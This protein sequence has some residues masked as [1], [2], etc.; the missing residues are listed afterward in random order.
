MHPPLPTVS[1]KPLLHPYASFLLEGR[2][3][4][5]HPFRNIRKPWNVVKKSLKQVFTVSVNGSDGN[6]RSPK[7]SSLSTLGKHKLSTFLLV[8]VQNAVR[9]RLEIKHHHSQE[10]TNKQ[11]NK[12]QAEVSRGHWERVAFNWARGRRCQ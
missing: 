11:Q 2:T 5:G 7:Y 12:K 9:E 6:S 10:K 4:L 3:L 8:Y 1:L